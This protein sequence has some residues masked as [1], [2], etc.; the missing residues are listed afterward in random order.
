[1]ALRRAQ[2]PRALA[3]VAPPEG[4]DPDVL[5]RAVQDLER[6]LGDVQDAR[7]LTS[8]V[9]VANLVV[10]VNKINHGLGRAP[11][12]ATVVPTV[13]DSTWSWAWLRTTATNPKSQVWIECLGID[14]T[15]ATILVY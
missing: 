12:F 3:K 4:S 13:A 9:I 7:V 1:M 6:D 5:E 10:G 2:R 11:V 15:G 8:Q 14:Q